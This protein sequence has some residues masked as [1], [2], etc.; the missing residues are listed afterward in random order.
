MCLPVGLSKSK[1]CQSYVNSI[2]G[3]FLLRS[4]SM[5]LARRR[6]RL[7]RKKNDDDVTCII[8]E[9]ILAL[10]RS[11]SRIQQFLQQWGAKGSP[12]ALLLMCFPFLCPFRLYSTRDGPIISGKQPRAWISEADLC[13][14]WSKHPHHHGAWYVPTGMLGGMTKNL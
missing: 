11:S 6:K 1:K 5:T 14:H 4:C 8:Y 9:P 2:L 12:S 3:H 10:V 7:S 13:H